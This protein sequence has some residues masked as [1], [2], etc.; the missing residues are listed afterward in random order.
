MI[1]DSSVHLH[2]YWNNY[3]KLD[4]TFNWGSS[5]VMKFI[6]DPSGNNMKK[7]FLICLACFAFC[8]CS[9][10]KVQ[11]KLKG[12]W[13]IEAMKY[14]GNDVLAD[15]LSN[16]VEIKRSEVTL[17]GKSN[18]EKTNWKLINTGE[19][20]FIEFDSKDDAFKGKFKITFYTA[21]DFIKVDLVSQTTSIKCSKSE[22]QEPPK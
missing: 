15:Y 22:F 17:P 7:I 8:S 20:Y 10:Y 11:K 18:L 5:S 9:T 19:D 13:V 2:F 3:C 6:Y 16:A 14:N 1:T 21:S 12:L 4:S